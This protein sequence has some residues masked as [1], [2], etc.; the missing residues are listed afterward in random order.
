MNC[1]LIAFPS[2]LISALPLTHL[3]RFALPLLDQR[4]V[5]GAAVL[6]GKPLRS[7]QTMQQQNVVTILCMNANMPRILSMLWKD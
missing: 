3:A 4:I 7:G 1:R 5:T 2:L 6:L